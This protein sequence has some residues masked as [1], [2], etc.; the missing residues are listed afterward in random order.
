[1]PGCGRGHG[2]A[3]L[4]RLGGGKE[5]HPPVLDARERLGRGQEGLYRRKQIPHRAGMRAQ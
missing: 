2:V 5:L 4:N 3:G 1:M